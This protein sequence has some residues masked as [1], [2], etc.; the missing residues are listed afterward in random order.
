MDGVIAGPS[1]GRGAGGGHINKL[2][3]MRLMRLKDKR[4]GRRGG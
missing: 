3:L 4:Q 1:D 2:M